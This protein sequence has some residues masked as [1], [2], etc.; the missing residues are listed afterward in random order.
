[1]KLLDT[2]A[3]TIFQHLPPTAQYGFNVQFDESRQNVT[4]FFHKPTYCARISLGVLSNAKLTVASSW[5]MSLGLNLITK[6]FLL[7][8]CWKESFKS[9]KTP[10][11]R[12]AKSIVAT[13]EVIVPLFVRMGDL[14]VRTWFGVAKILTLDGML[15]TSC[16]DR[17]ILGI[18]PT[19]RE[20]LPWNSRPVAIISTITAINWIN[21][22]SLVST[23]NTQ[24]QQDASNDKF[25]LCRASRQITIPAHMQ[26]PLVLS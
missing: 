20:I 1:M 3:K 25:N 5:D 26:A 11:M 10:Q 18:F 6:D 4:P 2:S 12:S 17:C 23:E 19:E 22:V 16:T 14:R 8:A 21:A 7:Q 24:S 9:S 13:V 15:G